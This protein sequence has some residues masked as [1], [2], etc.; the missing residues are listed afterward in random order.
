MAFKQYNSNGEVMPDQPTDGAGFK[1]VGFVKR[2]FISQSGKFAKLTLD[3]PGPKGEK[4]LDVRAFDAEVIG[5]IAPLA[6]GARV[7]VLGRVDSEPVKNKA[8]EKVMIDGYAQWV[9]A[10]TATK[11]TV[12]PSSKKPANKPA[13]NPLGNDDVNW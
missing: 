10:L 12:D 1:I 3:V 2:K 5:D 11:V 6:D 4:K 13:A 9:A 7:T 8:G